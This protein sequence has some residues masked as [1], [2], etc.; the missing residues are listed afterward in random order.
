MPTEQPTSEIHP[1][2]PLSAAPWIGSHPSSGSNSNNT[3]AATTSLE[4]TIVSTEEVPKCGDGTTTTVER[5]IKLRVALPPSYTGKQLKSLNV[6]VHQAAPPTPS[7]SPHVGNSSCSPA[8][9]PSSLSETGFQ[10]DKHFDEQVSP[11]TVP[12]SPQGCVINPETASSSSVSPNYVPSSHSAT[13]NDKKNRMR[14]TTTRNSQTAATPTQ[15]SPKKKR[16]R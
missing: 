13:R 8:W 10:Q 16:R 12:S 7:P 3:A 14:S 2:A 5:E 6:R 9:V 1:I 4:I 15:S 11:A